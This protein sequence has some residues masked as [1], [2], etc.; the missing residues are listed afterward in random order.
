MAT[1]KYE[2]SWKQFEKDIHS[3]DAEKAYQAGVAFDETR[4]EELKNS[5]Q[6][7]RW[8]ESRKASIAKDKPTFAKQW[9]KEEKEEV[10]NILKKYLK[11]GIIMGK[12]RPCPGY[13]LVKPLPREDL[14][15]N[16][17]YLPAHAETP[18]PNK[19]ICIGVGKDKVHAGGV[20]E[21]APCKEGETVMY[22]FNTLEL[23]INGEKHNLMGYGD[24]LGIMEE[25]E[26]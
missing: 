20:I 7:R 8:E 5:A 12:F 4:K 26:K 18:E 17:I 3:D 16:G 1:L 2:P 25:D 6:A 11:G 15:K 21:E 23:S 13:I 24:V 22:K 9:R 14:T 10:D 19:G